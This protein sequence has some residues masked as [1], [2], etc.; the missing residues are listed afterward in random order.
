MMTGE[1]IG[2]SDRGLTLGDGLF[3]TLL[4]E[5]GVLRDVAPHLARMAAGC[6]VLG[7]PPPDPAQAEGR[8]RQA[9]AAAGLLGGR[10]AVRLTL[11]AGAGGRGL[12]RPEAPVPVLFAAAAPAPALARPA[13]LILAEVRRNDASPA[14][15]LKTLSYLD[16][17]LARR[18]ARAAGADEAVM[19]NTRGEVACAAAANIFWLS[20]DVL[21]TPALD[22]GV[23]AGIARA[24]VLNAAVELGLVVREVRAGPDAL[25]EADAVF[26]TNSLIGV[27]AVG[28]LA[29]RDVAQAEII[30]SKIR[31]AAFAAFA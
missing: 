4:A 16:N 23:L 17:V 7:L 2:L 26:L 31:T 5:D 9:L 20:G 30:V 21:N 28:R 13:H 1:T 29:G 27:Q 15:R 8:L 19:L 14:S 10:A 6:A 11:T 18:E 22:C 25:R 12:D 24:R 3:E